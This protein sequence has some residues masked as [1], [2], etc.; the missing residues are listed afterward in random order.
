MKIQKNSYRFSLGSAET[1]LLKLASAYCIFVNGGKKIN[2]II[3]DRVQDVDGK[4]IYNTEKRYCFNCDKISFTGKE[5]PTI[6][7]N[8][9]Q[10]ISP[11]HHF[12]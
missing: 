8:Y 7:D 12:K 1:T 3:I 5:I 4:T 2:P 11:K 9:K 10:V 6:K